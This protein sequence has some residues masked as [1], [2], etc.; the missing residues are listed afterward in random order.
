MKTIQ[1][2]VAVLATVMVAITAVAGAV[3]VPVMDSTYNLMD[4]MLT[5]N[6]K[7]LAQ[8]Y[9]S[10]VVVPAL[11]TGE[12]VAPFLRI[13]SNG[14]TNSPLLAPV[15]WQDD[16]VGGL[17]GDFNAAQ[18]ASLWYGLEYEVDKDLK[19]DTVARV[20]TGGEILSLIQGI[21][22]G[23]TSPVFAFDQNQTPN[24]GL[25]S[26]LPVGWGT[27]PALARDIWIRGRIILVK[28][29]A[30]GGLG[31]LLGLTAQGVNGIIDPLIAAGDPGV[32]VF[33]LSDTIFGDFPGS[34]NWVY[35]PGIY[36]TEGFTADNNGDAA[37]GDWGGFC[38]SLDLTQYTDY[39]MFIEVQA[40]F[41]NDG[42]EEIYIIGGMGGGEEII[43]EPVTLLGVFVGIA[44]LAGY[45]RRRDVPGGRKLA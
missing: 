25:N 24:T 31:S 15:K 26:P 12:N 45:I 30:V 28:P 35:L 40:L 4:D 20:L 27:T 1:I 37:R 6:W 14:N 17:Y 34:P 18:S 11:P 5:F 8:K 38:P 23:S 36:Q 33:N 10:S 19:I 43:P 2:Q 29:D 13:Y 32:V 44:G 7:I 39:G 16:K 22:P 41:D 3:T 9:P 21:N 42:Q